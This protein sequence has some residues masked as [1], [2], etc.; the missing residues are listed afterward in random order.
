MTK[1]LTT[2]EQLD[3]ISRAWGNQ[4]G[5]CFFP[6]V[7]GSVTTKVE[8][9]QSYR[10][11]PAYRWP[12]ERDKI[13]EHLQVHTDDDVWWCPNLF[14]QRSRRAEYAMDERALWAD[15]D[16]VDPKDIDERYRPSIAWE[17][18]PGRFQALWLLRGAGRLNM[19]WPG[20]ENHKL[21]YYLGADVSGWDATQLLRLPGWENHKPDRREANGGKPWRGKL[22][23]N[24]VR[25]FLVHEFDEL[26]DVQTVSPMEAAILEEQLESVD[27]HEVWARVKARLPRHIQDFIRAKQTSGDRSEV[28]W[29]IE[30]SL[31]DA[32]CSLAEVVAI[33][34]ATVWNKY[35]GR[36]DELRRLTEESFKAIQL[37]GPIEEEIE[38]R[39]DRLLRIQEA[40][41]AA[42]P[43]EWLV[44]DI[45]TEGA[46]GF[47][48]G[49]PKSFKSWFGLDLALAI[50]T[51]EPFLGRFE[52]VKTGPV[53][54]IQEEDSIGLLK[55]RYNIMM[56]ST[57][58]TAQLEGES[59]TD[60][61]T[62][63][64]TPSSPRP[65]DP[66]V[67]VMVRK[68]FQLT[69]DGDR[70]WLDECLSQKQY[71][72][73]ILD[74]FVNLIGGLDVTDRTGDLQAKVLRPLRQLAEKYGVAIIVIH[75]LRKAGKDD[76]GIRGGQR[77]LGSTVLHGWTDDSMFI[78]HDKGNLKVEVE[79][80]QG[81][82]GG[83]KVKRIRNKYWAP[84]VT[85]VDLGEDAEEQEPQVTV[86][87]AS[88]NG[89]SRP[90]KLV[91]LMEADGRIAFTA[92]DIAKL[93]KTTPNNIYKPI[94]RALKSGAVT[95]TGSSYYL[96]VES[97]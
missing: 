28:L 50:A 18:S 49:E 68:G 84:I 67:E 44:Q 27:R 36:Q 38:K 6:W 15:L 8:R 17:T 91:E 7:D 72:A 74:P 69:E 24:S 62:L 60:A 10:E 83:F 78:I 30:R 42:E 39:S 13:I 77:M 5:Y 12:R 70:E 82:G 41:D 90:L 45:W 31:A 56:G 14:E 53:I 47:I 29:Q 46:C 23:I 2:E 35:V 34:R 80:K 21:T 93:L 43:P 63:T 1:I 11:G 48:A 52:V 58:E 87:Q 9:I 71:R 75:H 51:G 85:E 54:Y 4:K 76:N 37:K 89:S 32:G 66:D 19:S 94:Q 86:N 96:T 81:Q 88:E 16:E 59:E 97:R 25:K 92:Q 95:K 3:I 55:K 40:V 22:I 65:R 26:P 57:R 64:I 33:V 61:G 20:Y 79:S 73:V